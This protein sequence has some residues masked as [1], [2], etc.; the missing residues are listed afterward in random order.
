MTY[1]HKQENI[2]T[3]CNILYCFSYRFQ[4][5]KFLV[6]VMYLFSLIDFQRKLNYAVQLLHTFTPICSAA[7]KCNEVNKNCDFKH[8]N[9]IIKLRKKD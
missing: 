6:V 1:S 5:S 7:Y 9:T 2:S 8:L 4:H 3:G